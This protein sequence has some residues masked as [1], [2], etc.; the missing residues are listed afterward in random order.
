MSAWL[1]ILIDWDQ[2]GTLTNCNGH[3]ILTDWN[4]P[5]WDPDIQNERGT[6]TSMESCLIIRISMGD[7]CQLGMS[8][9]L[10]NIEHN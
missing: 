8:I 9:G 6:L 10:I 7:P 3:E 2:H 4:E 1:G 5:F